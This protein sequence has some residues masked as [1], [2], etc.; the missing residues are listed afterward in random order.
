M[1]ELDAAA[2]Q[3]VQSNAFEQ[4][5]DTLYLSEIFKW[6]PGDFASYRQAAI[7]GANE[8]QTRALWFIAKYADDRTAGRVTAGALA[9]DWASYDWSLT[10]AP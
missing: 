4:K 5:G 8:A 2:S 1:S 3:W 7:P 6:F 9:L 10:G